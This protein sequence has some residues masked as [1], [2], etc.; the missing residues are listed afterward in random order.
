VNT[1]EL[2]VVGVLVA[3]PAAARSRRA[4]KRR[5]LDGPG[6]RC[7]APGS[8][9]GEVAERK[10]RVGRRLRPTT[11]ERSVSM[12]AEGSALITAGGTKVFV[13]ASVMPKVPAFL[14]GTGSGWITA[15][16]AMLPRATKDRKARA[17]AGTRPD[18]RSLEIQRLVGRSLR[19]TCE[20]G[21]LNSH[22]VVVDCDVL[23]A[24]GGTR[25]ASV[26]AGVVAVVEAL[27]WMKRKGIIPGVPMKG[28]VAA[29]SAVWRGG[30]PVLDPDYEAD[31]SAEA[32]LNAVFRESGEIVELQVTGERAAVPEEN[33]SLMVDLAREGAS[34][35]SGIIRGALGGELLGEAGLST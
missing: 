25:V 7:D 21:Y 13:T 23:Q 14:A 18:G 17:G 19:Q 26:N 6:R 1:K 12:H 31:S 29:S 28:L 34:E 3:T 27:V 33:L 4:A 16:Y 11:I 15:E 24:D 30:E 9:A 2:G 35:V 5:A 22:A 20:L 32:D 10:A 8:S